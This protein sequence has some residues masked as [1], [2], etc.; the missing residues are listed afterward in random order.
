MDIT[1]AMTC[2]NYSTVGT[3]MGFCRS[4]DSGV[5]GRIHVLV[6]TSKN[7]GA[8]PYAARDPL[9]WVHH[10]S[11]DR[12][13]ASWNANGGVNPATATWAT[14]VFGFADRTGTRVTGRLKD[15]F[16]TALLGYAY[17]AL[18]PPPAAAKRAASLTATTVER[19]AASTRMAELSSPQTLITLRKLPNAK[20]TSAV[21]GLAPVSSAQ[22]TYLVLKNLHTWKQPEVLYHVYLTPTRGGGLNHNS[23]VGALHFFD[24]EFHDHGDGG[25]LDAALGENFFSFDVT[26]LLRRYERGGAVVREALEVTIVAGGRARPDAGSMIAAGELLRQ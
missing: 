5:H 26:D 8:V 9:F 23:Y 17:D 6:G 16:D 2:P 24:A 3:V 18:I 21:L 20:P 10:A 14:K 11:I 7:M 25:K 22:R 13:W 15:F 12:M 4:I 19:V 1:A